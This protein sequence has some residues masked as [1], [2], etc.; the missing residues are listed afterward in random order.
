LHPLALKSTLTPKRVCIPDEPDQWIEYKPL[1][2]GQFIDLLEAGHS[3]PAYAMALIQLVVTG[4]SYDV[5]LSPEAIRDDLDAKTFKWL[6]E[7]VMEWAGLRAPDEKKDSTSPSPPTLEPDT[8][9][10]QQTSDT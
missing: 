4:W 10:S 7:N 9:G 2:A 1:S 8:D 3:G 6:D 5:P